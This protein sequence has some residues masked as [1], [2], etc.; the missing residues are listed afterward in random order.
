MGFVVSGQRVS[1]RSPAQRRRARGKSRHGAL[2]ILIL[3]QM[4]LPASVTH[5]CVG[6]FVDGA[7]TSSALVRVRAGHSD[8]CVF[9]FAIVCDKSCLLSCGVLLLPAWH[10]GS[11]VKPRDMECHLNGAA[12]VGAY[13]SIERARAF[14]C[15]RATPCPLFPC[16]WCGERR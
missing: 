7:V 1:F 4:S 13:P 16:N 8:G 11:G 10:I 12:H 3:S 15:G 14:V 5:A 9:E 6:R 2:K